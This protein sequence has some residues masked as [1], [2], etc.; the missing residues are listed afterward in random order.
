MPNWREPHWSEGMLLV[1][2]HLQASHRYWDSML[3]AAWSGGSPFS[4]GF[5]ELV[6]SEAQI[7]EGVVSVER[8]R[9]RT[10]QGTWVVV[11]ENTS[12]AARPITDWLTKFP[13]GVVAYLAVPRLHEVRP[14]AAYAL[15]ADGPVTRYLV[16]PMELRDENTGDNAQQIEVHSMTGRL[17]FAEESQLPGY[18]SIPLVRVHLS[19]EEGGVPRRDESFVPPLMRMGAWP[20]LRRMVAEVIHEAGARNRELAAETVRGEMTFRSGVEEHTERL[21][22]LHVLNESLAVLRQM[23]AIEDVR[24]WVAYWELCRLAGKL[25]I[26]NADERVNP[27]RSVREYAPYDH[28]DLGGNF[29]TLCAH[30]RELLQAFSVGTVRW[31]DFEPRGEGEG[32]QVKLEE[33]WMGARREMFVGVHCSSLDENQLDTTLKRLDWKIASSDEVDWLYKAGMPGLRLQ[34]VRGVGMLPSNPEIKYYRVH[35]DTERWPKV[36][37]TKVLAMRCGPGAQVKLQELQVRFR[38]YVVLKK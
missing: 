22:M 3:G 21:L 26:F 6:L 1:P 32:S 8:C 4:W 35:R 9:L 37:T 23:V 5:E 33:D 18:E 13:D 36:E 19:G 2:Q 17:L 12:V 31:R 7:K 10:P 16:E 11:P 27:D 24:P 38:L 28:Y 29:G 25:S 20:D 15:S 14:N 30:I 34:P